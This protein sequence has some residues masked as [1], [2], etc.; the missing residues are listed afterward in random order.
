VAIS[1]ARLRDAGGS[2]RSS[3]SVGLSV[4]IGSWRFDGEP[5]AQ[6]K[7]NCTRS[8]R[9]K[10]ANHNRHV[11]TAGAARLLDVLIQIVV[12]I[13]GVPVGSA[14]GMNVGD[15]L[16]VSLLMGM[17]ASK[18]VVIEARLFGPSFRRGNERGLEC[19]RNHGHHH[20]GCRESFEQ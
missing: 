16:R 17:T 5:R 3:Q 10:D 14:V 15:L 2:W 6:G 19:E 18:A 13:D 20:D 12:V 11:P 1:H 4:P 7:S 9:G 8:W